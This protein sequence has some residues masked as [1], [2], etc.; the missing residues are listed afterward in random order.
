MRNRYRATTPPRP[1][2]PPFEHRNAGST[3]RQSSRPP[4]HAPTA[5]AAQPAAPRPRAVHAA[6]KL[7]SQPPAYEP[8]HHAAAPSRLM[9]Q[10]LDT[11][12]PQEPAATSR[13][14]YARSAP[15]RWRSRPRRSLR[16][17]LRPPPRIHAP[18]TGA[19]TK[20][21]ATALAS[22]RGAAALAARR[23]ETPRAAGRTNS[24]TVA[25]LRCEN[26]LYWYR[27][28]CSIQ[29]R[30]RTA[31][32]RKKCRS[33]SRVWSSTWSACR[34]LK[35]RSMRP[36]WSATALIQLVASVR[37]RSTMTPS[38]GALR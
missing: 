7:R 18:T 6:P 3:A 12:D 31:A 8:Q 35:R 10:I 23:I 33:R 20:S 13:L 38:D 4:G 25:D 1:D 29:R 14:R 30:R 19:G 21:Q 22:R 36:D 16:S 37:R 9:A 26:F 34:L 17:A 15:V 32:N 5:A 28:T 27:D 2:S 24:L 11:R